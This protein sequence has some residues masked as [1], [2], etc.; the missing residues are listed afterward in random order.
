MIVKKLWKVEK[1]NR[2]TEFTSSQKPR[3]QVWSRA[4][5]F[6]FGFLPLYI[7]DLKYEEIA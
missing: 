2:Y 4:G 3:R 5:W 7:K 1:R 6:L